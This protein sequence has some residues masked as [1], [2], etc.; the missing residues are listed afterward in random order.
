MHL[1][2]YIGWYEWYVFE[3]KFRKNVSRIH[4]F[5]TPFKTST[6]CHIFQYFTS[7]T[8][9]I[10][11]LRF[12]TFHVIKIASVFLIS[13]MIIFLWKIH[14]SSLWTILCKKALVAAFFL[15]VQGISSMRVVV[16]RRTLSRAAEVSSSYSA[17]RPF[18][19][20]FEPWYCVKGCSTDFVV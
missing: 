2:T 11:I 4:K 20:A 7:H 9:G 16:K 5:N 10:E 12:L 15:V 1:V 17:M 3:T 19:E 13:L 8:S 14:G 6:S 18:S